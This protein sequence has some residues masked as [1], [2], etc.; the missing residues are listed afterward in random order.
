MVRFVRAATR[1]GAGSLPAT[2]FSSVLTSDQ[3]TLRECL[4][5]CS[6]FR[7]TPPHSH[8]F[9]ARDAASTTSFVTPVQVRCRRSIKFKSLRNRLESSA[10]A[11]TVK[12]KTFLRLK[13]KGGMWPKPTRIYRGMFGGCGRPEHWRTA[14]AAGVMGCVCLRYRTGVILKLTAAIRRF[15][16]QDG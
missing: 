3:I 2:V 6:S 15:A 4:A 1:Q 5:R 10:A 8:W 11:Q 7:T 16:R 13:D 9:K 14:F 12:V